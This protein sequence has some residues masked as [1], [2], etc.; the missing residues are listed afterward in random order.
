[1][2]NTVPASLF[3]KPSDVEVDAMLELGTMAAAST[4]RALSRTTKTV[5]SAQARRSTALQLLYIVQ[6][7]DNQDSVFSTG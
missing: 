4:E 2:P 6:I 3:E 1:M 7:S 5:C